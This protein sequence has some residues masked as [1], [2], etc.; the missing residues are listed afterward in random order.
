MIWSAA[1]WRIKAPLR[2]PYF[3]VEKKIQKISLKAGNWTEVAS[4]WDPV[5]KLGDKMLLTA[6]ECSGVLHR[7]RQQTIGHGDH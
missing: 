1:V 7:S 5:R 3:F 2:R 4:N 6:K